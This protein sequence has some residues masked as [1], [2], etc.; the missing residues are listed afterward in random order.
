MHSLKDQVSEL[1]KS[2]PSS[3]RGSLEREEAAIDY[4]NASDKEIRKRLE[5]MMGYNTAKST[6]VQSYAVIDEEETE[7]KVNCLKVVTIW[8]QKMKLFV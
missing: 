4:R 1:H 8:E 3:R 5:S 6:P 7:R 2:N